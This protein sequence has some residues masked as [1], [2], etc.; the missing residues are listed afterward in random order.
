MDQGSDIIEDSEPFRDPD[1][2][3]L[4]RPNSNSIRCLDAEMPSCFET[5]AAAQFRLLAIILRRLGHLCQLGRLSDYH[6]G[7]RRPKTCR[8]FAILE[9][10]IELEF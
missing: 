6:G 2:R 5:T 3:S 8:H 10:R 1:A 7:A 9:I 4:M